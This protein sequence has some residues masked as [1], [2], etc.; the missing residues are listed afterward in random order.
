MFSDC[1]L[2]NSVH[3]NWNFVVGPGADG[4]DED[5][6]TISNLFIY[7]F[8][9]LL[10]KYIKTSL[11]WSLIIMKLSFNPYFL[12]LIDIDWLIDIC[13]YKKFEKCH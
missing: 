7:L 2:H 5:C 12:C 4:A 13:C 3:V 10:K 8:T 1:I 9:F 11:L 6:K